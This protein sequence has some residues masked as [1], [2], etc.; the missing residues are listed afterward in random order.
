LPP[1]WD[2]QAGA[3]RGSSYYRLPR[4]LQFFTGSIGLHHVHHLSPKIPNYELQRCLD[5]FPSLLQAPIVT[6]W[7][8]FRCASLKVWDDNQKRLVSWREV[9]LGDPRARYPSEIVEGEP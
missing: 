8:G 6:F 2:F 7:S 3:L 9:A 1:Q 5:A 4:V